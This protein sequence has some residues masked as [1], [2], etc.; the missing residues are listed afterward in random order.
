MSSTFSRQKLLQQFAARFFNHTLYFP[1]DKC[2]ARTVIGPKLR[3]AGLWRLRSSRAPT[4]TLRGAKKK[5]KKN[6]PLEQEEE[7]TFSK[8]KKSLPLEE[9]KG[10]T[11]FRN[12]KKVSVG[13][14]ERNT[15]K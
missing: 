5:K 2:Y 9:E 12:K 8:K 11:L 6:L 1:R 4:I 10:G 13:K 3:P 7:E 14:K 15:M